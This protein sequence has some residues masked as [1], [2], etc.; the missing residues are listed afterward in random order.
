MQLPTTVVRI[1]RKHA[2]LSVPVSLVAY[3]ESIECQHDMIHACPSKNR[4]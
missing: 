2:I 4:V 3:S 1:F